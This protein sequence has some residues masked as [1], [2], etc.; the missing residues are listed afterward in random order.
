[1]ITASAKGEP[2][3]KRDTASARLIL[4]APGGGG[5]GRSFE[6][7]DVNVITLSEPL[8]RG[9]TLFGAPATRVAFACGAT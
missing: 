7:E 8:L 4:A 2:A 3:S 5:G 9:F 6:L 1:M